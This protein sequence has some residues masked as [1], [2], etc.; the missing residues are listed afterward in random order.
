E[1]LTT[2]G[3]ALGTVSYMSPEQTRG[4][5][6]DSRTDLSSLGT[7]LYQMATGML[8]FQADTSAVVSEAILIRDPAPIT[9]LN[10]I[11]PPAFARIVEKALQT[12]RN[13]RYQTAADLKN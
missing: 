13:L 10:P 6:T 5:L 9:L 11:L 3:T 4:Q 12:D 7:G 8:P 2:P 1:D